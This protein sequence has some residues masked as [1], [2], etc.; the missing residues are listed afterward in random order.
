MRNL[1][2]DNLY[3]QLAKAIF[4]A[5]TVVVLLWL[6][7]KMVS[8]ILLLLFAI[9]L[10]LAINDPIIRLERRNIKR[11]WASTIVFTCILLS[12]AAIAFFAGPKINDQISLLIEN[13]PGYA[14]QASD[15]VSSWFSKY[16]E[17]QKE[18]K[19]DSGNVGSLFPS[20]SNTLVQ[21]GNFSLSILAQVLV[22]IV[23]ISMV[24]YMVTN[25]RPLFELYLLIFPPGQRDKATIAFS[26]ISV[27]V[28]G[29]MRSNIIGGIMNAVLVT[30][31]LTIMGIPG[32][33]VW[34]ALAFFAEFI[35]R[36]GF[37]IKAIPPILVALSISGYTATWVVVFYL[38]VD[39]IMADFIMPRIRSNTMKIHP[40]S[41]LFVVLAMGV[42]FGFIGILL[43]TPL[44]AMIKAYFEVFYLNKFDDDKLMNKRIHHMMYQNEPMQ[45]NG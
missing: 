18:I 41:I 13:L 9:V 3:K 22:V 7:Y 43:A 30:G 2:S 32:A 24:G 8:V 38:V 1:R 35:P 14:I 25:P 42:A 17:I 23:F 16:P 6:C 10:A 20:M 5:A 4:L 29:W 19:I 44:T 37:F 28:R 36:I 45:N 15:T 31:F 27:M 40:V 34:G 39:E 12:F 26:R 33:F 11:V 21:V